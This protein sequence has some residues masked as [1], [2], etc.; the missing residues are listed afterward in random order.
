MRTAKP[1]VAAAQAF[2]SGSDIRAYEYLGFHR[3]GDH[4]VFRVWAPHADSVSVIGDFNEWSEARDQ[5]DAIGGG[6]WE[7]TLDGTRVH[8]GDFY[9]FC[10]QNGS[11][12]LEKADPFGR[13]CE[14]PPKTA[15]VIPDR[16]RHVWRDGGWLAYR[17]EH[18]TR[19]AAQRQPI[20]I[21]ELHV[22][23]WR[24]HEDGSPCTYSELACE[25]VSY[26]KQMG[27]THVELMPL[28]EHPFDGSWGYQVSGYYAPTARYGSPDELMELIDSLHE[29]GIGVILDWVPAHF[30]KDAHGLCEFDGQPLFEY[31]IPHRM[32]HPTWGTRCFDLGRPEVRSFLLSN[33]AYWIE[34]Y[35][36]DGLR[37]DAVA[38]MLYLDFDRADGNWTPNAEGGTTDPEAADFFRTLN[39][40]IGAAYPDVMLIAEESAAR[41]RLTD[42]K[43]GLGFTFK[44]NMGWMNDALSYW[45]KTQRERSFAHGE[46]T[47][48]FSYAHDECYILPISHDEVVHGKRSLLDRNPGSYEEKFAGTRAFFTYMMTH[49]GKKLTFMGCEIGQFREWNAEESVEWFLLDYEKHAQ[50]QLFVAE[51]NH[52]YLSEPALWE[53]DR[54]PAGFALIDGENAAQSILSYRRRARDGS[55]LVVL[56]N[57]APKAY[58][59]FLLAVPTDGEYTEVWNSDAAR[60]GGGGRENRGTYRAEP[61]ML[62]GYSRAIRI[63][64]PAF[65]ALIFRSVASPVPLPSGRHAPRRKKTAR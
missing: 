7:A 21:Y 61:C 65:S 41:E 12:R 8:E 24:R 60:F 10:I 25:L 15:S 23:S 40:Q 32:E 4:A 22:G 39:A 14:R 52:F 31:A 37:T 20:N 34:H 62:R 33:A 46:L 29:A 48:S 42:G 35:H 13:R 45:K 57:L 19:E 58:D 43:D 2:R 11:R 47:F 54:E 26:V 28:A 49:P 1:I 9:K 64:L 59:D 17:A 30:P 5:M 51:L 3:E 63:G 38:S 6:I 27:Y 53:C 16:N 36:A 50:L 18:F 56:L 55:E 44:W